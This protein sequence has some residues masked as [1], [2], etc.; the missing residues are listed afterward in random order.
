MLFRS[1]L[2]V[3]PEDFVFNKNRFSVFAR[4]SSGLEPILRA[5]QIENLLVCGTLT[6]VCVESTARDAMQ[7]GYKTVIVSDACATRSDAEHLGTLVTFLTSF[8]DVRTAKETLALLGSGAR[9]IRAA[10]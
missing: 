10:Q 6:N 3:R 7:L 5:K 9:D 8:G 1:E 2:N 4:G